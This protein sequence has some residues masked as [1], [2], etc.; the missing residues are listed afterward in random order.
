M[1]LVLA[2]VIALPAAAT[3]QTIWNVTTPDIQSVVNQAS[4]GDV[5]VLTPPTLYRGFTLSKGLTIRGSDANIGASP[6]GT[7]SDYS[8][9]IAVPPGQV[10]HLERI[11]TSY[12]YAPWGTVG[13]RVKVTSGSVRFEDCTL[14]SDYAL[15][16]T[17]AQVVVTGGSVIGWATPN[18]GTFAIEATNSHLSLRNC[19]VT[20]NVSSC[21]YPTCQT[22]LPART[23]IKAIDSVLHAEGVTVQGGSQSSVPSPGAPAVDLQNSAAYFTDCS[24]TGG[25]GTVGATALVN[26]GAPAELRNTMLT[27]GSP[28]GQA[29]IGLVVVNNSLTR[30]DIAPAWQ[31]GVTSTMTISGE[32][33]APFY[34]FLTPATASS[35]IPLAVEPVWDTGAVGLV[36]GVLDPQGLA[37]LGLPV[38]NDPALQHATAW[39]QVVSGASFPLR[40][41]T[42]AG[43]VV[44]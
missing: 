42:I 20:G 24:L 36:F 43:G 15:Q 34:L 8:I 7:T 9:V 44:R 23:A 13:C 33:S 21:S 30:L 38:P 37:V 27:G 6:G 1:R 29:S 32:P 35:T 3:A 22:L 11:D 10:A 19:L 41:S 2:A 16:I 12:A 26:N 28:G 18:T 5:L 4:P 40:A 17:N 31:R 39:F 14:R 25:S